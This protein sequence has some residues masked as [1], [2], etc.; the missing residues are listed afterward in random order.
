M[1]EQKAADIEWDE[2]ESGLLPNDAVLCGVYEQ[3]K[4]REIENEVS[5]K[6]EIIYNYIA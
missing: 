4:Q 1:T 3:T 5:H 6:Y 2:R